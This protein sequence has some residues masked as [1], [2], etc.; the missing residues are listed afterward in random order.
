MQIIGYYFGA[1]LI[2]WLFACLFT[3]GKT[4]SMDDNAKKE[5]KKVR[6]IWCLFIALVLALVLFGVSSTA[7]A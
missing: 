6:F 5:F 3:I 2:T 4:K 1:L 7:M